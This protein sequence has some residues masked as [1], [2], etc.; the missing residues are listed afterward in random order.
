MSFK[1][2]YLGRIA[3]I[4]YALAFHTKNASS[5]R[6]ETMAFDDYEN[7]QSLLVSFR[8]VK[9]QSGFIS[10]HLSTARTVAFRSIRHA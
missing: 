3:C 8:F 10:S 6:R 2:G 1:R 4:Y 5:I 9:G 7:L